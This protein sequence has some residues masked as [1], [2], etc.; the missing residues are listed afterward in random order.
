[1]VSRPRLRRWSSYDAAVVVRVLAVVT[2]ELPLDS[3]RASAIREVRVVGWRVGAARQ[4][5]FVLCGCDQRT[6]AHSDYRDDSQP[7]TEQRSF[8]R[9]QAHA[10]LVV[11]PIESR[12]KS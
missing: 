1:M 6:P 2:E 3:D 5:G 4:R 9:S 10:S 12:G 7:A 8:E 11:A